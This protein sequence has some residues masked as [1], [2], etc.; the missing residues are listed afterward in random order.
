MLR[1]VACRWKHA[2]KCWKMYPFP[3]PCRCL[4]NPEKTEDMKSHRKKCAL[5]TKIKNRHIGL[6]YD[7]EQSLKNSK[8]DKQ[9]NG[10][11][12]KLPHFACNLFPDEFH[13]AHMIQHQL[14]SLSETAQCMSSTR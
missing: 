10:A 14:P 11:F 4:G 9:C 8:Q 6:I 12:V 3:K 2:K 5:K 13:A 7:S 1:G